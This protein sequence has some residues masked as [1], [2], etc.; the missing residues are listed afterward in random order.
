MGTFLRTGLSIAAAA[1]LATSFVFTPESLPDVPLCP[2][3]AWLGVSCP[4]C[5]MTRGFCAIV[6]GHFAQAWSFNPFAFVFFGAAVVLALL[7]LF[8]G[9]S[10]DLETRWMRSRPLGILALA[11]AVAMLVFGFGRVW[12]ELASRT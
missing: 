8:A 5:G 7:P 6:H 12:S 2:M 3:R 4:G 10:P 1:V 11:L 9:I